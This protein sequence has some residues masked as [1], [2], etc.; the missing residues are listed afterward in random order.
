MIVM[1][2]D[3]WKTV[4]LFL[5]AH[6][7][8]GA[9]VQCDSDLSSGQDSIEQLSERVAEPGS[10]GCPSCPVRLCRKFDGDA[11][12]QRHVEIVLTGRTKSSFTAEGHE[13]FVHESLLTDTADNRYS[14]THSTAFWL[15]RLGLR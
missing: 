7:L 3:L 6:R 13:E 1:A 8:L 14:L 12:R 15:S 11:M 5:S 10:E 9:S 4:V 2:R